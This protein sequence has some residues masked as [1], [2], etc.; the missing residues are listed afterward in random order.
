MEYRRTLLDSAARLVCLTWQPKKAGWGKPMRP[1][2]SRGIAV[3]FGF[4][5]SS[6]RL[7]PKS[8]WSKDGQVQVS[9]VVCAVDCGQ[10]VN[11]DTIRAQ[12]EGGIIFRD[13]RSSL[14]GQITIKDGRVEQTNFD[15]KCCA[16]MKRRRSEVH[17]IDSNEAQ[18]ALES[19]DWQS[20]LLVNAI[21][22]AT[23]KRLQIA[24]RRRSLQ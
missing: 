3:V 17:L 24:D 19:R 6:R 22:A 13:H 16:S 14:Y 5:T 21:F 20:R 10:M 9:R 2:G 4:G 15:C 8:L 1:G 23:G 12:I 18:G 11:P 7:L